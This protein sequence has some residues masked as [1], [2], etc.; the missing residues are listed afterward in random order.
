MHESKKSLDDIF[1][2]PGVGGLEPGTEQTLSEKHELLH[3]L[4]A[5]LQEA[6]AS[7]EAA[8]AIAP[9][10]SAGGD[11]FRSGSDDS[12]P[13]VAS[14]PTGLGWFAVGRH[15][16]MV[17][18]AIL[19]MVLV[20]VGAVLGFRQFAADGPTDESRASLVA[21]QKALEAD[22]R[23]LDSARGDAVAL[24]QASLDDAAHL[25][26]TLA[27]LAGFADAPALANTTQAVAG[28]R[29]GL[30]A[31]VMPELPDADILGDVGSHAADGVDA[32]WEQVRQ[33]RATVA[34]L[35]TEVE[36]IQPRVTAMDAMLAEATEAFAATFPAHAHVLLAENPLASEAFR[37]ALPPAATAVIASVVG[38]RFGTA[39]VQAYVAAV[40]ALRA[41][42]DRA[43][44]ENQAREDAERAEDD[45]PVIPEEPSMPVPS[46]TT[47]PTPPPA[48]PTEP[49]VDPSPEPEDPSEP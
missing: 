30:E 44:A 12:P 37:E 16:L 46:P 34:E 43:L 18:S 23:E 8:E 7:G 13:G 40:T 19:V 27:Q 10:S 35:I 31:V 29:A 9:P 39:E 21:G 1:G 20:G 49:P 4:F 15:R 26:A 45:R 5:T 3:S 48:E 2:E 22:L 24:K 41:D 17:T 33:W 28:H 11:P 6:P 38:V 14:S 25:E 32:E 42:N 47:E 36:R